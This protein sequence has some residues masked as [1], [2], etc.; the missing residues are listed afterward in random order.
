LQ[1][2]KLHAFHIEGIQMNIRASL[3]ASSL[4]LCSLPAFGDESSP[5]LVSVTGSAEVKVA[6]DEIHLTLGVETRDANLDQAKSQNDAKIAAVLKSLKEGGVDA[7]DIQTAYIR[8]EPNYEHNVSRVDPVYY[9]VTRS[10]GVRV[11]K[12]DAYE[13][14][15]TSVIRAGA[16]RVYGIDLHTTQM[17]KHRDTARQMAMRAAKEKAEA[18]AG[19][20]GVKIGKVYNISEQSAGGYWLGSRFNSTSNSVA[21]EI[22][23]P[24][25]VEDAAFAVGQISV[26]ASVSVSFRIE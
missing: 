16:N 3:F 11:R 25:D 7:K 10:V 18:L 17:R 22:G 14:L 26:S 9:E 15:L 8:V 23:G 1:V 21:N 13:K 4:L 19:E 2:G 6:P 5:P 20:L 12:V 24:A